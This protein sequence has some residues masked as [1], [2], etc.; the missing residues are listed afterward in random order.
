YEIKF[1]PGE[2]CFF[3]SDGLPDQIG[4]DEGRKYRPG[5]IKE[6][7]E[8]NPELTMAQYRELFEK[9]FFEWKGN[10][11]QVDDILLIGIEF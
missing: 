1:A 8:A 2:K 3:F 11:K 7:I 9:D 5:R 4:G 10:N 6:L